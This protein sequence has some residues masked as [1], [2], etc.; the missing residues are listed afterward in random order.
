MLKTMMFRSAYMK[1][2]LGASV[3]VLGC[4]DSLRGRKFSDLLTYLPSHACTN[5]MSH[6]YF[7]FPATQRHR[8]LA[9]TH[10]PTRW[11]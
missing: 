1:H 10:F 11:G 6:T 7:Y 4:K 9:G 5:G 3:T 2:D 8:I